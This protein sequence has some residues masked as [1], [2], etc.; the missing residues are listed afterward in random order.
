MIYPSAKINQLKVN[1]KMYKTHVIRKFA[2]IFDLLFKIIIELS[3]CF[4]ILNTLHK[5]HKTGLINWTKNVYID[6]NCS[7]NIDALNSMA[8]NK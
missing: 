4:L 7:E 8:I 5:H 2:Q 1:Y 3:Q 6:M